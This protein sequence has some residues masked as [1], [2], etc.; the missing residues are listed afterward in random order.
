MPFRFL[1][2]SPVA[3]APVEIREESLEGLFA[4]AAE[5]LLQIQMEDVGSLHR[6]QRQTIQVAH[7][8]VDM[9]LHR[10]LQELIFLKDSKKWLL[11]ADEIILEKKK[12]GYKLKAVM[13]GERFD[14][15]CHES[16]MAVKAISEEG[17]EVAQTAQG[18]KANLV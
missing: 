13:S 6:D 2:D 3:D 1:D 11:L 4:T 7:A 5:A 10:F 17:L 14:P 16:R 15:T 18:W 9:L 8:D 12:I